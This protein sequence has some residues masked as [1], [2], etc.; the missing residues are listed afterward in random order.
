MLSAGR[1]DVVRVCDGVECDVDVD[2]RERGKAEMP[3]D[4]AGW[5]ED[6]QIEMVDQAAVR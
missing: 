4:I 6:C 3:E 2:G 1:G 5:S